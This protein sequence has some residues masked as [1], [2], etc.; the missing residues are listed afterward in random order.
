MTSTIVSKIFKA[1][2]NILDIMLYNGFDTDAYKGFTMDNVNVMYNTT[3]QLNMLLSNPTTKQR[4][5][6]KFHMGLPLRNFQIINNIIGQLF[7]QQQQQEEAGVYNSVSIPNLLKTDILF[8]IAD[9]EPSDTLK[10]DIKHIWNKDGYCVIVVGLQQLQYNILNHQIVPNHSII[11]D[12]EVDELRK[13][14]NITDLS[15]MPEIDRF[16]PVACLIC[17]RPGQIVKIMRPSKTAGIT[18][19]YRVCV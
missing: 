17:V 3:D 7:K 12:E 9:D 10:T 16:D 2:T 5:Y 11:Y 19:Y 13:K 8:I 6:I 14:Y 1:R 4:I 15:Q 18:K